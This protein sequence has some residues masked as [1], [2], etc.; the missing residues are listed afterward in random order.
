MAVSESQF[1]NNVTGTIGQL[2]RAI[3]ELRTLAEIY[4]ARGGVT[5][6]T[7]GAIGGSGMTANDLL[8][9]IYFNNDLQSFLNNGTPAQANR[10]P[11]VQHFR[12]DL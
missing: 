1:A 9:L 7:D 3:E 2:A 5:T 11:T 6:Y 10:W 8:G 12:G 4:D